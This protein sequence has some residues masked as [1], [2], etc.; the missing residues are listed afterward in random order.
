MTDCLLIVPR[1]CY[2]RYEDEG[3]AVEGIYY[4]YEVEESLWLARP[5]G[6]IMVRSTAVESASAGLEL[7]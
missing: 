5:I 4:H 6:C 7:I 1:T 2:N 3:S